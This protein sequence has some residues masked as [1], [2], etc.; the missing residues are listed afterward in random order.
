[1]F[2]ADFDALLVFLSCLSLA[3]WATDDFIISV[4][5]F[6]FEAHKRRVVVDFIKLRVTSSF[7]SIVA[8]SS[9]F[10]LLYLNLLKAFVS[11]LANQHQ[12]V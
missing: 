1:M 6:C 12:E 9:R 2:W 11:L 10:F 4:L 8:V 3:E 7:V 5:F